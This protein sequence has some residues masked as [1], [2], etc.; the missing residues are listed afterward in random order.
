MIPNIVLRTA[1]IISISSLSGTCEIKF[2]DRGIDEFATSC[3]LSNP[4]ATNGTG[5]YVE[6]SVDS[7][8][9]IGFGWMGQPYVMGY[10]PN[11]SFES[12]FT[13]NNNI[14]LNSS[15]LAK[16]NGLPGETFIKGFKNTYMHFSTNGAINSKFGTS[17]SLQSS[18][19]IVTLKTSD[20]YE[21]LQSHYSVSG[22]IKR[23]RGVQEQLVTDEKLTSL[24][25]ED[26]LYEVGRKPDLSIGLKSSSDKRGSTLKRN[27][28]CAET[29]NVHN[30]LDR[31]EAE[32]GEIPGEADSRVED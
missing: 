20:K 2:T 12:L 23:E 25:F 15:F 1:K 18:D 7:N 16:P 4:L 32:R 31:A 14:N 8:V 22:V 6:P 13:Q 5:V 26:G 30:E 24:L 21:S 17:V 27:P 9:L 28:P 11:P 29:R 3:L 19:D 10:L